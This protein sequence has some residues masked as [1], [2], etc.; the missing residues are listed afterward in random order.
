[1]SILG[2]FYVFYVSLSF[3][4]TFVSVKFSQQVI[5]NCVPCILVICSLR[6]HFLYFRKEEDAKSL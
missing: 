2:L 5:K 1:M 3:V 6:L 4:I